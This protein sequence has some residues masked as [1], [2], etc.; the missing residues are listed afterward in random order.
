VSE[1]KKRT[2]L[3]RGIHR[4]ADGRFRLYVT[5]QGKPVRLMVTWDLLLELKV[6]VPAT[7]LE[8]PGLELAKAALVKLQSKI[9]EEQRTGAIE[10]GAKVKIGDLFPLIEQD[11]REQ[12]FKSWDFVRMRWNAHLK[13]YFSNIVAAE[14]TTDHIRGYIEVRFKE[15]ASPS[16]INRELALVR[17]ILNLGQRTRPPKVKNVLYIAKLAEPRARQGFLTD[18][19]YTKLAQECAKEGLWLRGM[20]SVGCNFGWRKSE[21]R[22]LQVRQLDFPGQAIRLDPGTTKNDDGRVVRM[23]SEVYQLLSACAIGK[24]PLDFVFTRDDD[25]RVLDFRGAWEQ[26]CERAGC[27]GLLFHDLRRT[28]ARNLRR[29]GVSEGVVMKIGGWRSRNVFERYNIVDEQDL[30]DAAR[31]LDEKRDLAATTT[32][33]KTDTASKTEMVQPR[34]Q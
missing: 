12:G 26:V 24:G 6:P 32:D 15:D 16:T 18:E 13:R 10:A 1:T 25:K 2:K 9:L 17:R 34:L 4:T 27:P 22:N 21:I 11:Y 19:I 29:L 20:F 30:A 7:R 8:N 3:P 5:R 14:L 28:A 31:R 33:I 23:T